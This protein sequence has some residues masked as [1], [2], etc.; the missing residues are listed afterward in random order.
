MVSV[1]EHRLANACNLANRYLE[2]WSKQYELLE[3][4]LPRENILYVKYEDLTNKNKRIGALKSIM[5]FIGFPDI[6]E[7][8][9]A[10]A[11]ALA[12]SKHAKVATTISRML[13]IL[14]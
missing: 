8:R 2:M 5:T 4:S 9:I 7:E 6:T 1:I 10:C 11:F 12:N 3:K 13:L 14:Y